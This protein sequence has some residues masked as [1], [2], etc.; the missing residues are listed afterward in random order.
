MQNPPK[1]SILMPVYNEAGTIKE[2]IARV[3]SITIPG[4]SKEQLQ[5]IAVKY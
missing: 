2:I 1:V 4:A 3:H 5:R